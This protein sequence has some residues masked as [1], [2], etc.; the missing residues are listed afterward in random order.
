MSTATTPR[1]AWLWIRSRRSAYYL[2]RWTDGTDTC[3]ELAVCD[4]HGNLV[5]L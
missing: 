2:L 1:P 5:L 4:D 3:D